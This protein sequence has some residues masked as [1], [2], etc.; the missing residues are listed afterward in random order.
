MLDLARERGLKALALAGRLEDG[1]GDAFDAVAE[2]GPEGLR[3]P[4]ELLEAR[5]AELARS[6]A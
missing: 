1:A 2:L 4:A 6:V 3:R 5:A